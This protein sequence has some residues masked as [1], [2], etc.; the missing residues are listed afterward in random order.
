VLYGGKGTDVAQFNGARDDYVI[1]AL[2]WGKQGLG[3]PRGYEVRSATEGV[4]FIGSDVEYLAFSDGQIALDWEA[5][6]VPETD[7]DESGV[8]LVGVVYATCE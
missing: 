7:L 8:R 5:P 6:A 3:A 1:T 4:D 2:Y